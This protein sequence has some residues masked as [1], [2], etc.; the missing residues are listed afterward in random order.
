MYTIGQ[1]TLGLNMVRTRSNLVVWLQ[2]ADKPIDKKNGQKGCFF[3]Q[4]KEAF[5]TEKRKCPRYPMSLPVYLPELDAWGQTDNVSLDGCFV[6]ID[7]PMGDGFTLDML[8]DLPVVGTVSLKVYV[9]HT[10]RH[11]AGM[12]L[13]LVTVRFDKNQTYY[14]NL[15]ARF[16]KIISQLEEVRGTYL[17]MVQRGELRILTI[18]KKNVALNSYKS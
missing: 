9:Q 8:I 10:R 4:I 16:I 12:G 15:Y 1:T 6:S 2:D 5:M 13:Q 7:K 14:Y 18:P 17:E 3:I 11:P